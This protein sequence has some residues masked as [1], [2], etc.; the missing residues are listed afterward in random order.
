MGLWDQGTWND[1]ASGRA[2]QGSGRFQGGHDLSTEQDLTT[3]GTECMCLHAC[4]CIPGRGVSLCKSPGKQQVMWFADVHQAH[5][6][7][8]SS[9][10]L[11]C[12]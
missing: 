2:G 1:C 5:P 4:V 8:L 6:S 9:P 7:I 3:Y 11:P 12:W 10:G